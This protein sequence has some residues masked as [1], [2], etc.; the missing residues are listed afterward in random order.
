MKKL[1]FSLI[2]GVALIA[3]TSV[4]TQ[5]CSGTVTVCDSQWDKFVDDFEKN[6]DVHDT[7]MVDVIEG[8]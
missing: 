5:A 2:A 6:C 7:V 1:I 8:C 4:Q 3:G